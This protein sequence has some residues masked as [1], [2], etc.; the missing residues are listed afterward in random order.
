MNKKTIII[1]GIII[2]A[3]IAGSF[4]FLQKGNVQEKNNIKKEEIK[5]VTNKAKDINVAIS[6]SEQN[7][8]KLSFDEVDTSNWKTYQNEEFG[9]E[10]RYPN[11]WKY[12]FKQN[13]YGDT[14]IIRPISCSDT[15]GYYEDDCDD[16]VIVLITDYSNDK[17]KTISGWS[18]ATS[19]RSGQVDKYTDNV[20][21]VKLNI[22]DNFKA[23]LTNE[24]GKIHH[25]YF[26][27]HDGLK[28]LFTV[29]YFDQKHNPKIE[30]TILETFHFIKK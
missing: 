30:K 6:D 7:I 10:V 1:L 21:Q 16:L 27:E 9:F 25:R 26:F 5:T 23:H 11:E 4:W 12:E 24:F 8:E 2:L 20:M 14:L 29:R 28:Y 22:D 17:L 15:Y 18:W 3:I 19:E 13:N